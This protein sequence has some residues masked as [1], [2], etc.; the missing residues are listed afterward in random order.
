MS[1]LALDGYTDFDITPFQLGHKYFK[2]I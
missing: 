2:A 1:D